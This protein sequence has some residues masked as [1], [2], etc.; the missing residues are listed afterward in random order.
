M[1]TLLPNEAA[2]Y[3]SKQGYDDMEENRLL[4]LILLC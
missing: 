4:Q 3:T 1:L 2:N